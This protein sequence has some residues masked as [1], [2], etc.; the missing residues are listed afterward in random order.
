MAIYLL[1]KEH[2][3]TGL[4]YL[5][6]H[7]ASSFSDCEKYKGSGIYWKNHLKKYGNNVKT[8]CLFVTDDKEEFRKIAKNYSILLNVKESKQWANLCNEEGQGGDT[9]IDKK[10]HGEKSKKTWLIPEVREKLLKHLETHIEVI[11]PKAIEASKRKMT[12]VSKTEE[13][14]QNMR[15]K[16][17]HVNQSGSNN[18]NAKKI[19]TPFGTFGSIREASQQIEGYTYEMI[20]HKLHSDKEWRYLKSQ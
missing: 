16:R 12:G 8:T 17:P 18:N 19:E 1:I 13:H 7:V 4:K 6:K 20:R 9:I 10:K 5:C 2:A 14:K 15:G 3:D 11:R